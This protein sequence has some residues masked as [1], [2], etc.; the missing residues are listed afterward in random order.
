MAWW[1]RPRS[2]P[3]WPAK[4]GVVGLTKVTA[5]ETAGM[6][7]T[8]Q[9]HL[10]RLGAHAVG[11]KADHRPGGQGRR[12]PGKRRAR[13][14]RREAAVAA[15]RHAR[16]TGRTAVFLASE[17]A[18]QITGTTISVDGGWTAPLVVKIQ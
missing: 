4:H 16:A 17:A 10:P 13:T 9:R 14:A 5:L 2:P 1:P 15:V 7:I 11:G 18:A 6:G 8:A 3:T 12:R